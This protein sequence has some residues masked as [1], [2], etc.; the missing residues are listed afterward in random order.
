MTLRFLICSRLREGSVQR[1][2]ESEVSGAVPE[3][4]SLAFVGAAAAGASTLAGV[5]L[6]AGIGGGGTAAIRAGATDDEFVEM[7]G[8]GDRTVS[9]AAGA[10]GVADAEPTTTRI[11]PAGRSSLLTL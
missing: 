5:E 10:G 9:R 11:R 2:L 4:G 3:P 7:G 8:A 1:W 6:A